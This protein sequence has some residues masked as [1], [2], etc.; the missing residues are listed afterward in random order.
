VRIN[1][2]GP[3][4]GQKHRRKRI[5]RGY[6]SGHGAQSTKGHKGQKARSGPGLHPKFEGGQ[7]PLVKRMPSKRGFTNIFRKEYATVNLRRLG[8]FAAGAEVTPEALYQMG[9][10]KPRG[11]PVKILG[12]GELA[13][14]LT[15]RAHRFSAAAKAKIEAAGG[16]AEEIAN[17]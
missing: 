1:E 10:A 8:A 2:I 14:A 5:G 16:K 7:N 13:H 11:A 15:V 4:P 9:L 6:G 3:V 17:A 12:D